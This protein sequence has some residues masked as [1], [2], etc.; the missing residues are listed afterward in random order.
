MA[1][2][3]VGTSGWMYKGWRAHLYADT[4]VKRWLH[5]ASRAFGALEINGSFYGQIRAETYAR[6]AAETPPDFRFCVKGHRYITH[7]KRLRDC[8]EPIARVREPAL[9]LG[10]KLAAVVWQ[11]PARMAVDLPRLDGFLRDLRAVWPETRHALELRDRSWFSPAVA[12]RLAAAGVANVLSDAP[13]FPLWREVTT[14]FV[15]VRLHGHTRKYASSYS[16]ANLARWAA[17]AR[18]WLAEGR[19]VHVYFDNDAE[20]HAVRNARA[21]ATLLDVAAP[22]ALPPRTAASRLPPRPYALAPWR[23]VRRATP[24]RRASLDR[25]LAERHARPIGA[26]WRWQE[27]P[28]RLMR[29]RETRLRGWRRTRRAPRGARGACVR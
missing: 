1:R 9:A 6:F 14:D 23:S 28:G 19:D 8:A 20:G 24:R 7:Y 17:D 27:V 3:F 18:G 21:L 26:P 13:D 12:A 4:P 29:A 25:A 10:A 2:A 5:V 15:Y 16:A 11:L 22:F